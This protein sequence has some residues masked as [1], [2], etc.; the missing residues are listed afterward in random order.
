MSSFCLTTHV[1]V[2]GIVMLGSLACVGQSSSGSGVAGVAKWRDPA[3]HSVQM[4]TVEKDVQLEVLDWGGKGRA[5]VLLTGLGNTAH[6]FDDFAPK[7]TGEYH[8][9]GVTRR[10]YG[11]SS[12]P[13][14]GY[15]SDRLGDDVLAVLDALKIVK[16]VL[17]GH[18]IA[19]EELSSIATRYPERIAGAVYLDA[20]YS[21]AYYDP[22]V[23]DMNIDLID[24]QK[25]LFQLSKQPPE[26]RPL[27]KEL[28]ETDL[29]AFERDLQRFQSQF[30]T[31]VSSRGPRQDPTA[32]DRATFA[33]YREWQ[34]RVDHLPFPEAEL[35]QQFEEGPDGS[36][37]RWKAKGFV[38]EAIA[39]GQQKYMKLQVPMLAIYGVDNGHEAGAQIAAFERGNPSAP[40]IRLPHA[41][42]YVYLSNEAEVLR[43]TREFINRLP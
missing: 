25:K 14:S 20:A 35:R 36:V 33:A 7:L 22:S 40:V 43:A 27:V 2:L 31:M 12:A 16:P 34:A 21:F 3:A 37:G 19:G 4:I 30:E 8:V 39:A 23:G 9:Y 42:H 17:V 6:V 24:L 13:A 1:R 5:V 38:A 15:G 26:P 29:P 32:A 18:S 10:G 28:L 11:V 41:N